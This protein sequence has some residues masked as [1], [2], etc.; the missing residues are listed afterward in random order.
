MQIESVAQIETKAYE[1][2]RLI[3]GFGVYN[4]YKRYNRRYNVHKYYMKKIK[5]KSKKIYSKHF[6]CIIK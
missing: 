3:M 1:I 6:F 5:T 4:V 2:T